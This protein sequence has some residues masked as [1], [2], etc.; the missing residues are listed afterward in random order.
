MKRLLLTAAFA[1]GLSV[2]AAH[3]AAVF[4]RVGPPAPQREVIVARPT[5]R[6]VWVPGYYRWSGARYA[7]APGYWSVPP[8]ARTTWVPGY[9][10]NRPGGFVWVTGYWR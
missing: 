7:W 6:H 8:R 10:A 1:I 9:W 3:A 2:S 4:V 5:P